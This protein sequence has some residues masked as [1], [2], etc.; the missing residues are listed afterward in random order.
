MVD[1]LYFQTWDAGTTGGS[2]TI[3]TAWTDTTS[4]VTN[5][6]T[7]FTDLTTTANYTAL[8]FKV[9]FAPWLNQTATVRLP[10]LLTD[11]GGAWVTPPRALVTPA[12]AAAEARRKK[13]IAARARKLL[14]DHLEAGELDQ[15]AAHGY[16]EVESTT[17][18]RRYRIYRG[19]SRNVVELDKDGLAVARLCAYPSAALPDEDHMLA[20]RL[21]LQSAEDEFR[22][23]AYHTKIGAVER[24]QL[25]AA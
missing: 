7:A 21:F 3:T 14:R 15:L 24:A 12:E 5:L 20:Q 19:H 10:Y 23:V 22:K 1:P 2:Y 13:R 8:K 18:G 9:M 17:S 6:T 16:F 11:T 25:A 4:S